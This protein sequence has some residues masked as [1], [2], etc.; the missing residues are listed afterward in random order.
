MNSGKCKIGGSTDQ[1]PDAFKDVFEHKRG[2]YAIV[3]L[4]EEG[5]RFGK[6]L[7]TFALID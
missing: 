3:L 2:P 7:V 5:M 6:F 1:E 4:I